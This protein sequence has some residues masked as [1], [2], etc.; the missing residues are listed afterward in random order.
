MGNGVGLDT[1]AGNDQ[2]CCEAMAEAGYTRSTYDFAEGGL[3]DG[4]AL[5][6]RLKAGPTND[7][8]A[9]DGSR[10]LRDH[11][12]LDDYR[13]WFGGFVGQSCASAGRPNAGAN[14]RERSVFS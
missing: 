10:R 3:T 9:L 8:T 2:C 13:T 7:F 11:V 4:D 6:D 14:R 12:P 1:P 5:I